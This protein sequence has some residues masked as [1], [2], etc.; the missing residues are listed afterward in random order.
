MKLVD[1]MR[2][3]T[4]L[5]QNGMTTNTTTLN[6][7]TDLYGTI[8][9]M[10]GQDKTRLIR[11]FSAAYAEDPMT[12]MRI[13]FWARDVRE[14]QG[15]RQ[16]FRD[17]FELFLIANHPDVAEKNTSIIP[18]FGRWDDLL[19]AENTVFEK[20]VLDF[21]ASALRTENG[22]CAKWMP[23]KGSFA[24]KLRKIMSLSP[25]EYRQL[26]VGL[27][28]TVEQKMCAKEFGAINYS[29]VP[30]LAMSRYMTAFHKQDADRF[31]QFREA[32]KRG[33]AGVKVNAGAVYPYDIIK[34]I[35]YGGDKTVN[36]KQ[37]ESLV[38]YLVG[39]KE[40]I[41]PMCDV[42]GSMQRP[43]GGNKNLS[44]L[45]V[46]LSL[47]MY[48]SERNEGPFKDAFISFTEKPTLQYLK[49]NVADRLQ[50]FGGHIGYNTNL[51]AAFRSMLDHAVKHSIVQ[52]EMPT[53]LLIISDMEFDAFRD[54]DNPTAQKMVEKLYEQANAKLKA[55]GKDIVYV[56]PKTIWWKVNAMQDN[57]P[58]QFGKT[59]SAVISGFSPSLMKSVLSGDLAEFTPYNVMMKTI[60][61]PRYD[62]VQI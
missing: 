12:A 7:C 57:H 61:V 19:L 43:V 36:Q 8:G 4:G 15:E 46:A 31:V 17:I 25:K 28:N 62:V 49:G 6:A 50:Q 59:G 41:M 1:A 29:H 35:K 16:V 58:V 32:L 26:L 34:S 52:E 38:N 40:R 55:D 54:W 20:S 22:L 14:G 18:E 47:G 27:S 24:N 44:A 37:W 21:I 30:S 53:M 56:V 42:S 39:S 45:D 5:T 9:A 2:T 10:R 60:S 51:E 33:D 13:L 23:R 48:I 3:E 11:M